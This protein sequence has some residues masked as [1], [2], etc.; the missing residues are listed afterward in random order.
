MIWH[1]AGGGVG[2][3]PHGPGA[4]GRIRS[5]PV[6]WRVLRMESRPN[7]VLFMAD[8]LRRDALGCHGNTICR[9]PNLDVFCTDHGDA[10]GGHGHFEKAGT[11]YDEIFRSL[12]AAGRTEP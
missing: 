1:R 8:Q 7:I 4:R 12:A 9:T 2:G 3:D 10:L 11:M 5:E 6:V